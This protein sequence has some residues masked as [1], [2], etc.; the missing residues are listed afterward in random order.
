MGFDLDSNYNTFREEVYELKNSLTEE[1]IIEILSTFGATNYLDKDECIIFPTICHNLEAD[2]ASLKLYY[3]KSTHIFHCYT[4]CGES[5]D[6]YK[7]VQKAFAVRGESK[8]FFDAFLYVKEIAQFHKKILTH[9]FLNIKKYKSKEKYIAE[10]PE[11]S[12]E[13][14]N[15]YLDYYYSGWID[16]GISIQTMKKF[17]IKLSISDNKICIPHYDIN[18]RLLGIR[19]RCLD[20]R[21]AELFGKYM[22]LKVEDRYLSHPLSLN[23]YGINWNKENIKQSK[24]AILFEGEKSCLKFEDLFDFN[25]SLAV[26]GSSLNIN[27]VNILRALGVQE[28]VLAFDKEFVNLNSVEATQYYNKL[29]SLCQKYSNFASFSFIY[30]FYN[31]LDYK[32][33]PIDKGKDNFIKLFNNRIKI[34]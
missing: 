6:I 27:Q 2:K 1:Q 10:I 19:G 18:G 15:L 33:S 23:L 21:E 29:K 4:D 14:L 5:F 31:L 9:N 22:P 24:T 34:N 16:E 11:L 12:P 20:P 25:N 7:L 30:D 17:Q 32:D 26:C 28:I 3:Y 13:L 8:T